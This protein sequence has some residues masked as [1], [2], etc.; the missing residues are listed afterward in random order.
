M[1]PA[2]SRDRLLRQAADVRMSGQHCLDCIAEHPVPIDDIDACHDRS[3]CACGT[4]DKEGAEAFS[5]SWSVSQILRCGY[6]VN[7]DQ[8][9]ERTVKRIVIYANADRLRL[10]KAFANGK[11]DEVDGVLEPEFLEDV[12]RGASAPCSG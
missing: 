12:A 2:R 7:R 11:T 4:L 6:R 1:P 3:P 9:R 10:D 5:L 8:R